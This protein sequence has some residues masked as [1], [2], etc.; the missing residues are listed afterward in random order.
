MKL[1]VTSSARRRSRASDSS[2]SLVIEALDWRRLIVLALGGIDPTER[3]QMTVQA[4]RRWI[5]RERRG[6]CTEFADQCREPLPPGLEHRGPVVELGHGATRLTR[7]YEAREFD[8]IA[9]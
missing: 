8:R 4:C 2:R 9:R 7:H 6:A 3:M 1:D 5:C